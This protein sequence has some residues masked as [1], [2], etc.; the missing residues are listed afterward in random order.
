MRN[1]LEEYGN[2][3]NFCDPAVRTQ[4]L[5][6]ITETVDWLYA[7]GESAPLVDYETRIAKFREIGEAI[8]TRYRFYEALPDTSAEY[9]KVMARINQKLSEA[10]TLTEEDRAQIIAKVTV[11]QEFFDKMK[12]DLQKQQKWE[13]PAVTNGSALDKFRLLESE[14]TSILNKPPPKPKEEKKEEKK[15]EPEPA[16]EQQ[17]EDQPMT[18]PVTADDL[19]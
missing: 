6:D 3:V 17:A 10:T 18:D 5:A 9:E 8:R 14:C 7:A 13:N 11:A 12:A 2:F 16:P 1:N 19:S 15:S 4:F